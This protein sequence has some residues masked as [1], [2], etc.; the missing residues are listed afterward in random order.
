M[1]E[2]VTLRE[3]IDQR[4]SD[5]NR[6]VEAALAAQEKAV[7]KAEAAAEARFVL[8][9][10]LRQGVATKEQVEAIEKLMQTLTDRMNV[11]DGKTT[12]MDKSW[13]ILLG[14]VGSVATIIGVTLAFNK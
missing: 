11:N 12:G 13:A 10:E 5:A 8:L 3:Y 9:N 2:M 4:F 7:L 6:A 1:S 14:V